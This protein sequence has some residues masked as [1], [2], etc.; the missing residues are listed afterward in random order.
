MVLWCAEEEEE[1]EEDV[2]GLVSISWTC[3]EKRSSR[4]EWGRWGRWWW[5]EDEDDELQVH[6]SCIYILIYYY[7]CII[8]YALHI[9]IRNSSSW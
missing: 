6:V 2:S 7:T 3:E 5:E 9:S 8:K 4:R 1:E